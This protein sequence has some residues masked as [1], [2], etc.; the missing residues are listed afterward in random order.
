VP[1]IPEPPG[2][3]SVDQDEVDPCPA[4]A[5]EDEEFFQGPDPES[6]EEAINKFLEGMEDQE[7]SGF[8]G[9]DRSLGRLTVPASKE[10]RSMSHSEAR[11]D[12]FLAYMDAEEQKR[13]KPSELLSPDLQACAGI[14]VY[15]LI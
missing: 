10:T 7:C 1:V 15:T 13:F 9:I 6:K 4:P 5:R 3:A 12:E 8:K 14:Q 11:A 2:Q